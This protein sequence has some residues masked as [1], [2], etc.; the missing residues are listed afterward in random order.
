MIIIIAVFVIF[1]AICASGSSSH[2]SSGQ[3][4]SAPLKSTSKPAAPTHINRAA[5]TPITKQNFRQNLKTLTD[6]E[7]LHLQTTAEVKQYIAAA[8]NYNTVSRK[9]F[10]RAPS[11]PQISIDMTWADDLSDL[12]QQTDMLY[13]NVMLTCN[14]KLSSDRFQY[15][16][17]L[18][19]RSFTAAD[20]CHAKGKEIEACLNREID[21]LFKRL[22]DRKDPAHLQKSDYEQL[23]SIAKNMRSI[24]S[25]LFDRRNQLNRQTAVIRHKIG[26][27]CGRGGQAW[28]ASILASKGAR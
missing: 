9:A 26:T 1:F 10:H 16:N 8:K 2:S 25:F 14:K 13:S 28:E 22:N 18:Y 3:K 23:C 20:L 6:R 24:K 11:S 5:R 21:P 4:P 19:F 12:L 7:D 27:D 17:N 15:Y